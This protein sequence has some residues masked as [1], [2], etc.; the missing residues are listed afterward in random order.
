M[1][2]PLLSLFGFIAFVM[3][4][5]LLVTLSQ[6]PQSVQVA[7]PPVLPAGPPEPRMV[8]PSTPTS[9]A[10]AL[11]AIARAESEAI[12]ELQAAARAFRV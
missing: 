10:A 2:G 3:L 8:V 5:V 1:T 6:P 7:A 4:I 12:A 9:L 11:D